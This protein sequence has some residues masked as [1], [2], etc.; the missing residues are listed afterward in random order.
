MPFSR[1]EA[2]RRLNGNVN[3]NFLFSIHNLQTAYTNLNCFNKN[4]FVLLCR[5]GEYPELC[6]LLHK[7]IKPKD[8]ILMVGCGN[9][10]LSADLYDVGYR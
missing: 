10:T 9:S 5:Y 4:I 7:Y 1:K 3:F 6:G 8:V 2:Q